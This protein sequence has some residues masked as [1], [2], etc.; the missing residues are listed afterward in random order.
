MRLSLSVLLVF[1]T[2]G[3]SSLGLG[4]D[5]KLEPRPLKLTTDRLWA[6]DT[7]FEEYLGPRHV[8]TMVPLVTDDRIYVGNPVHGLS[9]L[10][11]KTGQTLWQYKVLNGVA[12]GAVVDNNNVY[13]GGGDGFF[14]ALNKD[15]GNLKWKFATRFENLAAPLLKE[16]VIYFLSG[17]NVLYAL[18]SETGN[19]KWNYSRPGT[20]PITLRGGSQP[21]MAGQTLYV[22][23]SDGYLVALN[24][25]DGSL[26]WERQLNQSPRFRDVDASP[27]IDENFIY[28]SSYDGSL[29]C[30]DRKDGQISWRIEKGGAGDVTVHDR[31]LFVSSS[32]S[33][34]L[35]VEKKTGNIVWTVTSKNGVT[36][37]PVY[38]KEMVIYGESSGAI[39]M[40]DARDGRLLH[41]YDTGKGVLSRPVVDTAKNELYVQSVESKLFALKVSWV[42]PEGLM[43]WQSL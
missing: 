31:L 25:K 22:G 35:A 42:R 24:S 1:V 40:V 15:T 16:A 23:F 34:V 29:Y 2:V 19:L 20:T 33:E 4:P 27:I 18:D 32:Q 37:Q 17:N 26:S 39:R 30:L 8:H 38:F 28:I 36:S 11:R 41:S 7:F 14:Y 12:S 3:C 13:F 6:R 5:S 21:T 43:P 10:D 9:S